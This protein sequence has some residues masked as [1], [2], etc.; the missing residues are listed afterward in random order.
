MRKRRLVLLLVLFATLSASLLFA[1]SAGGRIEGKVTD[2]KGGAVAGASVTISDEANNQTFNAITDSQGRYKVE[3]LPAGIYSVVVSATGFGDGRKESVR[4]DEGASVPVDLKLEVAAVEANVTVAT[5]TTKA[6]ADPIYQRLRQQTRANQDTDAGSSA[7]NS[8]AVPDFAGAYATVNNLV[9]KKEGST[10]TLRNGEIYFLTP[11]L[12]RYT[13]AVFIGDGEFSLVPPTEN[14]KNNLKIFTNEPAITEQFSNLVMHFTDQTFANIKDSPATRMASSGPQSGKARDLFRENQ[15]LL[16]K[17]LRDNSELRVLADLYAPE[18]PGFFTAFING[19]RFNKLVYLFNPLGIPEVS[20]EEVLLFSYGEEDGGFWTAFHR[21]AEYQKGTANSSEDH[22]LVDITRHEIDGTIKGA[23]L[24]ATD[25][26]T[27]RALLPGRVVLL[28][29]YRTLRVNRVQDQQ[30]HDL[31]FIQEGK[32]EDADFGIIMPQPLETGKTYTL[33]VQYDGGDA[34]RDSGGGNFILVPRSTWYPNN[35]GTQFGDRAIFDMTF[36]YPRG[37]TFIGT[38]ALAGPVTQ[39]GDQTV[40]KWTSGTT[41]LAVAGFNYGKFKKRELADK[42]TGYNL[43]YYSNEEIPDELRAAQIAVEAAEQRGEETFTTLGSISTSKMADSLLLDAQNSTRIYNAF[44]G[45][46]PYSRIAMTQQPAGFFGQ[47][48]PT[49]IFMPYT[50]L[51]DTTQRT[52]LLGTRGGNNNF[53]RYVQPHEIAHQWWGHAVG[54][55][56]YHDQWMSEGFAEFSASLYVQFVRKDLNKFIDFWE[57]QRK[58]IVEATPATRNRK[59]YTVGPVTQGYRLN[60]GKTGGV[61]RFSIYPKG[62]YILHMIRMMMYDQQGRT[63]DS[64]FQKMM[65]DFIQTHYNRDVSTEDLKAMVEKHIT[66]EMDLTNNGKLDWFFNEYVYGTEMPSYNFDYQINSDGSLSGK[67]TQS[68]VSENFAMLVPLYVDFG[69]GWI[70][71]GSATMIGNSSV[72]IANMKLPSTPKKAAICALK[73]VLAA[74]IQNG[75]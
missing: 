33:T 5:G 37:Y 56:S 30:G 62:A 67:I 61:A 50:A 14:E 2:V 55:D 12:G 48:W 11:V 20:P 38:G 54:W 9:L 10:F 64:R 43:E 36:R 18:R 60:S 73:D 66:R 44:F 68:G 35:G 59:P 15:T 58:L 72:D 13:G 65:K 32:D 52:Q 4:V 70:K 21:L 51:I 40:A 41:D 1:H 23:H 45:K 3:G 31:D 27:L 53:W 29:L 47:A 42:S 63:A 28:N 71:V 19:K 6:N 8:E 24:N 34:L 17:R 46:V 75:K 49:L 22:R 57:D 7:A 74:S 39:E 16:R 69:G 26:L 25:R